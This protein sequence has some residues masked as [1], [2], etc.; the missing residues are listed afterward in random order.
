[1]FF[2]VWWL[3]LGGDRAAGAHPSSLT[4]A[5]VSPTMPMSVFS[6]ARTLATS[7]RP[8]AISPLSAASVLPIS[9]L[10][11]VSTRSTSALSAVSE[12][13]M[14]AL[15]ATLPMVSTKASAG[16]SAARLRRELSRRGG[17]RR[18]ANSCR[19]LYGGPGRYVN[20]GVKAGTEFP[21]QFVERVEWPNSVEGRLPSD[22]LDKGGLG[23]SRRRVE[24]RRRAVVAGRGS[25]WT[26]PP[27]QS[28]TA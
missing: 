11:V 13:A 3:P 19:L 6:S 17:C 10:S 26:Q 22:P 8:S 7:V 21:P 24:P 23:D 4:S 15:M 14:S 20:G 5:T 2:R 12:A 28:G 18:R 1:M 25:A 16:G 9:A 27:P